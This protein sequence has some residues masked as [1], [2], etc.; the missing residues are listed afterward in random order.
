MHTN[1]SN[2][3]CGLIEFI[4][5]NEAKW[6]AKLVVARV[7]RQYQQN[8]SRYGRFCSVIV[9]TKTSRHHD[10]PASKKYRARATALRSYITRHKLG[11]T[12]ANDYVRNPNTGNYIRTIIWDLDSEALRHHVCAKG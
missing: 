2:S 5:M 3:C 9:T 6:T 12:T 7:N 8:F 4:G 11:T 1:K 10:S